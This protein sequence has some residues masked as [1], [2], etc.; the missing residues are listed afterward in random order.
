MNDDLQC[1]DVHSKLNATRVARIV[2]PASTEDTAKA[3]VQAAAEGRAV[4]VCGARHAMGGQQFGEGTVLLDLSR[5]NRLGEVNRERGVVEAG[6]GM[7]WPD[8]MEGLHQ[9]QGG[10]QKVWSIRQKQ[11]GAD[12]LTLGGSLASNIHGRGLAMRPMVDDVEAFTL[13]DAEGETKRC[14]RAEHGELFRLVIGGYG[15]FGVVTSVCLRL[16]P[17]IKLQRL[18]EIATVD[19]LIPSMEERMAE[20]C[21]YGDFQFAIDERSSDF[22]HRGVLS[23]YRPVAPETEMPAT[24]QELGR[25]DWKELIRLAHTDRAKVFE[26]YKANGGGTTMTSLRDCDPR[27]RRTK[28]YKEGYKEKPARGYKEKPA[29]V[30]ERVFDLSAEPSLATRAAFPQPNR[31]GTSTETKPS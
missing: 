3:V 7:V 14:S 13:V 21:L 31:L 9:Q 8:L 23:T 18:V 15:C 22:L 10:E 2:R 20:G 6:A 11:T 17:R 24:R 16:A 25:S 29:R 30:N 1:N 5:F 12:H 27:G 28:G 19:R 26:V 4:S